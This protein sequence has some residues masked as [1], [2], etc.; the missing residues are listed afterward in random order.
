VNAKINIANIKR[1]TDRHGRRRIYYKPARGKLIPL[2]AEDDPGFLAA[3]QAA[4]DGSATPPPIGA[5][6][7]APGSVAALVVLYLTAPEWARL[8]PSTKRSAKRILER[9]R[10]EH[11]HR[12]A[13][14][15]Q[16]EQ[17]RALVRQRADKPAA[18][19]RLLKV[20]RALMRLAV[21]SGWRRDDPTREVRPVRYATQE[22]ATWS[23]ADIAR[24]LVRWPLGTREHLAL[25]LL[26]YTGQRQSDVVGLGPQHVRDG[27]IE[28]RQNKT[29][30][31][32]AVPIH[33]RLAEAIA[34]HPARHA[35]FI[36]TSDGRPFSVAGLGNW[37]REARTA[38]GMAP[39]MSPHGLRKAAA[40]RLAEAGCSAL[41]IQAVT[42][43][44]SLRELEVYVREADRTKLAD[45]A[46]ATLRKTER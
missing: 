27:R 15:M 13:A 21:D 11:G 17:V 34:A 6:K 5:S 28:L 8:A 41:Q 22:I 10:E 45:D 1:F 38:A 24:F 26:L 7:V 19:N 3:Y 2:P 4:R 37:L 20:L 16:I 31:A 25:H 29:G 33:P 9:L 44:R 43:H 39:G 12:P 30:N 32:V 36:V 35:V 46:F 42:G 40:R 18:A 23:E 14:T